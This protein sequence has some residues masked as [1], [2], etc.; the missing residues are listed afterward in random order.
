MASLLIKNIPPELH[1]CLRECAAANH[2][3]MNGEVIAIHDCC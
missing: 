2:R 3:S 1:N